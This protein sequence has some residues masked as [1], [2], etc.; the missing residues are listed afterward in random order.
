MSSWKWDTFFKNFESIYRNWK[1]YSFTWVNI[2]SSRVDAFLSGETISSYAKKLLFF[3]RQRDTIASHTQMCLLLV[4]GTLFSMSWQVNL[5]LKLWLLLEKRDSRFNLS[6]Q[7]VSFYFWQTKSLVRLF[8]YIIQS[9]VFIYVLLKSILLLLSGRQ[10]LDN[11]SK[12]LL[13]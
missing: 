13:L 2:V 8:Y 10:L 11:P 12:S 9:H 6:N 4:V 5:K 3:C 1:D 7:R